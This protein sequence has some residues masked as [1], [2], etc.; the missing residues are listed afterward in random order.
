MSNRDKDQAEPAFSVW[1]V[2]S[3]VWDVFVL[4]HHH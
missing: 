4:F 1:D 2:L 3:V